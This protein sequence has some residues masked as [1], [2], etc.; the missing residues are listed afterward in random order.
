MKAFTRV[1]VILHFSTSSEED[2]RA[3]NPRCRG[4][5]NAGKNAPVWGNNY[6]AIYATGI[7]GWI[8]SFQMFMDLV[9]SFAHG[10]G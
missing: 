4:S 2:G 8:T 9:Q 6:L 10:E 7:C 5:I 1:N 3:P